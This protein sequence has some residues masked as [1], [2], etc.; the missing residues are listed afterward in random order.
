MGEVE[1]EDGVAGLNDGH[2]GG[3]V[4]LR[5]GVRLDVG[6]I[7]A[8]ELFGAVAG[9]V[10]DHV[11]ILAAAVVALAGV[12]FGIFIGEDRTGRF[13]HRLADKVLRRDHLQAFM[14]ALNFMLHGGGNFGVGLGEREGHAVGRH[15]EILTY[16][17]GWILGAF[18]C[19]M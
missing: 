12:A 19:Y 2:V 8:E 9:Q 18:E 6:V 7:G 14:L 15:T 10:F 16:A 5:A 11:G 13:Q 1:A 4:G 17:D 3:G